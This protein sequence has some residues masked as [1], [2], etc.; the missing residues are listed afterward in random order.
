MDSL[1]ILLDCLD[2]IKSWFALHFLNVQKTEIV[3]FGPS[4]PRFSFRGDLAFWKIAVFH[5]RNK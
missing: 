2:D 3:L 4:D 1:K 5:L